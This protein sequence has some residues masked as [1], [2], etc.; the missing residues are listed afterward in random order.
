LIIFFVGP[1][2]TIQK[3]R[4]DA[5]GEKALFRRCLNKVFR[6]TLFNRHKKRIDIQPLTSSGAFHGY[7]DE[8]EEDLSY[9][10]DGIH[11]LAR[12]VF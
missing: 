5:Y 11:A 2:K 9:Y 4:R 6:K 8:K 3:P 10:S 7:T 12:H 1:K